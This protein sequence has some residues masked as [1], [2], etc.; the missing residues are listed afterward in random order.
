[1]GRNTGLNSKNKIT[2]KQ[3]QANIVKLAH[4]YGWHHY[5]TFNSK[6]SPKGWPDLVLCRPPVIL[7]IELKTNKGVVTPDQSKWL[8]MLKQCGLETFVWRPSDWNNDT[9]LNVLK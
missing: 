5:H 3:L 1:M 9:I 7:F 4:L 8:D 6:F 2:E